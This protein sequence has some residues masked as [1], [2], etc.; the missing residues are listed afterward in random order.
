MAYVT[1]EDMAGSFEAIVFPKSYE[2]YRELL[3]EDKI[4][5]MQGR[6]SA[7]DERDSQLICESVSPMNEE[8]PREI[9]VRLENKA[10]YQE[11][12]GYLRDII[13]RQPGSDQ[14]VVYLNQEKAVKREGAFN[15]GEA[16]LSELKERFGEKNVAVKKSSS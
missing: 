4:I 8:K 5:W 11:Q 6:I 16:A 2:R 14:L 10:V 7:D 15:A 3:E 13:F 12:A 9:W 1:L